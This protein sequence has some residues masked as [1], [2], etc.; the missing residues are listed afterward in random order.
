MDMSWL[1]GEAK[2]IHALFSGLFFSIVLTLL[3][4]GVV[5]NYFRMPLGAVPEF[6]HLVG[7]A[8]VAA[9]LLV[10][11]PEIMN[12]IA[13]VTDSFAG[14]V[15]DLHN[16]KLVTSRLGEKI[17]TLTWSWVSVKDSVL[18]II[19]YLTFF[20]LYISV[21]MADTLY[22]FTWTLLYIFSPMM[23]AAFVLPST[24]SATK[25]LFQALIEVSLW[26]ITWSVLA[27]LLWSFALSE[28]NKP[29]YDV[30]FL[31]AILLN[32][33]LAFSVIVTPLIVGKLVR[34]GLHSGAA[35]LGGTILGAAALTPTGVVGMA[36]AKALGTTRSIGKGA[37]RLIRSESSEKKQRINPKKTSETPN[38]TEK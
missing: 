14:Q 16:F 25:G 32:V 12:S 33:L 37:N 28:I 36:K 27:A 7:R 19:S 10:A 30:D 26:K 29:E 6:L 15:G 17:G 31:T 22:L 8:V 2:Q 38:D 24:A 18:L 13:D 35:S 5:L 4:L 23:I 20:L 34:G 9:F 21:Y 11:L 3:L 1:A